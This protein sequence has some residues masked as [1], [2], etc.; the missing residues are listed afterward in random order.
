MTRSQEV[1]SGTALVLAG[2][3][4]TLADPPMTTLGSIILLVGHV[5]VLLPL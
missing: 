4:C 3:G 2:I 1:S 5:I